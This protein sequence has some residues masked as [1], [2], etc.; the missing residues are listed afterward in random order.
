MLQFVGVYKLQFLWEVSLGGFE[1]RFR[2]GSE[3]CLEYL[4][5]TDEPELLSGNVTEF[6]IVGIRVHSDYGCRQD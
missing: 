3:G 2:R 5:E 4:E 1:I 6:G